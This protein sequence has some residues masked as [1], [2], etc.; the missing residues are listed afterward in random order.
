MS[1]LDRLAATIE[2]RK[3]ADPNSS[4][5]AKLLAKGPGI[6][7]GG[8][9]PPMGEDL[10]PTRFNRFG[11]NCA[12]DAL[13]AKAIGS[14]GY[15]IGIGYSGRVE[16]HFVCTRKEQRADI[17]NGPHTTANGEW[18]ETLLC[19]AGGQVIHRASVFVGGVDVQKAQLIRASLIIGTSGFDRVAR[20]D[21]IDKVHPLDDAALGDVETGNDPGF[22]H[23][24]TF[25]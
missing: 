8:L 3:G 15:D 10:P 6:D 16:A 20:I 22:Q 11:V 5:T 13:A 14:A 18:H 12:H 1:A 23:N 21:Q 17:V 9:A 19:R 7:P 24:V 2:A 4:W 25:C